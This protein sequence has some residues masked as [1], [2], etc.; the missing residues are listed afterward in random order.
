MKSLA[1]P[2]NLV[3]VRHADNLNLEAASWFT[4]DCARSNAR[5]A[6]KSTTAPVTA[7]DVKNV[8][9]VAHCAK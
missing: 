5:L 3:A 4:L 8:L 9:Y 6:D 2:A 1:E 7:L